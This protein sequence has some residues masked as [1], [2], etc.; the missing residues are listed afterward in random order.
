[1]AKF[2]VQKSTS[3]F[4]EVEIS[5]S[6]NAVLPIMAAALLSS[7]SCEIMAVP[8]LKDVAVMCDLL[9]SVGAKVSEDYKNN[10]IKI[11]TPLHVADETPFELVK[12]MR[13]SALVMGPLLA[14][15]GKVRVPLPGGCAIGKRPINL[16]LKGF[17][18]LGAE[19]I[20][21]PNYVEAKAS[22]LYGA[23]IYLDFP[24]VGA[25][26]NI[27]M[28]AALADGVSVVENAAKEPEIVDLAN[29]LNKMGAKIKGA[30]TDTIKIE[31]VPELSGC[32]HTVIPDRIETGTFMVAAA[33]TKGNLL[34]KNTLSDHLKPLIAKLKEC[35]VSVEYNDESIL[36]RADI[37]EIQA[38]D[39]KTLP[40]PGF[41]TDMQPQIAVALALSNGTSIVTESIFENR[42]R[43]VDELIRMGANIKVEGNTAIIDGVSKY[44]GASISAPD[45][46]AGAAL[47]IAGLAAEG[48]TLVGN[49]RYIDRGYEDLVQK[50]TNLGAQIRRVEIND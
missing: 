32:K 5:G 45:L 14:K 13:A 25:T 4:G 47:V 34:L 24:S 49:V 15:T 9:R 11:N 6:K 29:F 28:A 36:V 39:I 12:K 48:R 31:G 19:I 42:F 46:R 33:I 22:S 50:L 41:P 35:G 3:L 30:G 8:A 38:T 37:E 16:H 2:L 17:Q 43:Y 27:I 18:A 23:N 44:M 10:K 20:E 21:E 1:L 40:Y 7:E 26:E